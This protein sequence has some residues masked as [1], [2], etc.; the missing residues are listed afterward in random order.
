MN[1]IFKRFIAF[2]TLFFSMIVANAQ[3][4]VTT[5]HSANE[6]AKMLAGP[7]VFVSNA[8]YN[9][10][11]D[12]SIQSGKFFATASTIAMDSGIILTSGSALLAA[13]PSGS[14]ALGTNNLSDPDLAILTSPQAAKDA[15]VLEFD[16]IPLGDTI[17]FQYIFG[18]SEYSGFTCS[19]YVDAFGFFING[20]GITGTFSNSS[21][22][23]ALLPS[24]CFVSINTVNSSFANPCG[25]VFSPCAPPNNALFINNPFGSTASGIAYNGYTQQLTAT[26]VVVPCSTY[27]LKLAICDATD[28]TLDSGVFLKAGSLSSNNISLSFNTGFGTTNPFMIEGC[29]SLVIKIRRNVAGSLA[30]SADTVGILVSGNALMGAD[31]TPIPNAVYFTAS[32]TDTLQ[33]IVVYPLLDGITEPADFVTIQ[34]LQGCNGT[35]ADS[36]TIQIKDSLSFLLNN[37]NIAICDGQTVATSGVGYVGTNFVWTPTVGV[38]N[39]NSINTIITPPL[40]ATTYSVTGTYLG[41]PSETK[42]F[43]IIKDPIPNI[44]LLSTYSLCLGDQLQMNATIL[45]SNNLVYTWNPTTNLQNA[46]TLN[47]TFIGTSS[48]NISLTAVTNNAQCTKTETTAITVYAI[49][50][51]TTNIEDTLV[52]GGIAVNLIASGGLG[53]YLWFPNTNITCTN[54][55][56]PTVTPPLRT[57]YSVVFLEPH[58]CQD[59]AQVDVQINPAFTLTLVNKD[60]TIEAGETVLLS[61]YGAFGYNWYPNYYI[62]AT[63]ANEVYASPLENITYTIIGTD[64][65]NSCPQTFDVTIKVIE[66]DVWLPNVFTPNG[67]GINDVFRITKKTYIKLQEFRIFDRWGKEVFNANDIND[68]WNGTA[69]GK[70][71][72]IGTYYYTARWSFPSGK[73]GSLNGDILLMK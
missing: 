71:C 65:F 40:G 44:A 57:V 18:S 14:P 8:Y 11:C 29:D 64:T 72:D 36:I 43:K 45:P 58:G 17:K 55:P 37:V 2:S 13:G 26:A 50:N 10:G 24:G 23:I 27:H 6:M 33:T 41:C 48:Q 28:Q 32:N 46:N 21:K 61:A 1:L 15:C 49:A 22:N 67:D 39:I 42:S 52:C 70:K 62:S 66:K 3:I 51:G 54:C 63:N 25:T 16:F 59:T 60:T 19:N 73:V 31:Y 69:E 9:S 47:P 34:L 35:V 5:S 20:P 68:G 38:A 56:N 4:N 30:V 7:G 12:S 53:N